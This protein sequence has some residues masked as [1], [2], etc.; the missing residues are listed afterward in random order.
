MAKLVW[1][2]I[3]ER[4][5]E[6]GCDHGVLYPIK[7]GEYQK[8]VA[9]D[10]LSSVTDS[11]SGNEETAI[12]ADN[13]KYLSLRSA[14][15]YGFTIEYYYSPEEFDSCNGMHVAAPGVTLGQQKLSAFGLSWRTLIGNDVEGND[16][17]YK[18]H[19]AYNA[20]VTPTEHAYNTTNESPEA[21]TL[22]NEATTTP[23]PV[24]FVG[25]D[26]KPLKPTAQIVVDSTKVSPEKLKK[27]EDILYG[28]NG[29]DATEARLPLPNEV[30]TILAE[31]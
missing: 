28:T 13:I 17:G 27:L 5:Y 26:G 12:Y 22:S 2:Q 1:D 19:L 15:T 21:A 31:G 9:W 11:P 10:G 30:L 8:G 4:K 23:V 24:D 18:I 16:H 7:D 29:D 25:D 20:M 6:T 14:A 3:G